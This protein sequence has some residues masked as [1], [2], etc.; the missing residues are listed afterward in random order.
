[1]KRREYRVFYTTDEAEREDIVYAESFSL[2][3]RIAVFYLDGIIAAAYRDF[4]RV[5]EMVERA[6]D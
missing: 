6:E 2:F 1:L 5:I 4:D 3:K